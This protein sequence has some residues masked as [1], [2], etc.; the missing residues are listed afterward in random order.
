M[1]EQRAVL[2]AGPTAS[3]KSALALALAARRQAVIINADSMQVYTDLRIIT[4]RPTREQEW[5]HAHTLYGHVDAAETY[6]AGRWL[7]D[8]AVVLEEAVAVGRLPIIV[9]GTGL[10]FKLLTQ[11]IAD[12]PPIPDAVRGS[13]RTRLAEGGASAL[14]AELAHRDP[15]AAAR[16]ALADRSRIVRALEVLEATG[17]PLTAW[18]REPAT[19][20]LNVARTVAVFLAPARAAQVAAI[21]ARF[22]RML[23]NGAL[24]E[25]RLLAARGLDPLLPAMKAHGVPWLVR[26]LRG[27]MPIEQAAA[28]AKTDTR[29][30]AKRQATWFRNQL[31][32]WPWLPPED[33]LAY[34]LSALD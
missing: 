21:E 22:N 26:H 14:H 12:V 30:Y 2:I 7:R 11:G 6:S 5:L 34:L 8:V 32:G 15:D 20:L 16:I 3:G 25:V 23:A 4:A 10:Y 1:L 27:E 33:A 24:D 28:Q 31:P 13:I 9:G 17:R 18:Q 29:R 19:P